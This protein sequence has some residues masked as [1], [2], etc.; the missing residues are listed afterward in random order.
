MLKETWKTGL[1]NHRIPI[2]DGGLGLPLR[3]GAIVAEELPFGCSGSWTAAKVN[4][5][6]VR[7]LFSETC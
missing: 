1:P 3:Q 2:G 4:N 7:F 5:L 6:A